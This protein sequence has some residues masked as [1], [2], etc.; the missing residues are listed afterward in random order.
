MFLIALQTSIPSVKTRKT[1]PGCVRS[2]T[3][4]P[5]DGMGDMT[6][7]RYLS[8]IC[9]QIRKNVARPWYVLKKSK[10][11]YIEK[12]IIVAIN[13]NLLKLP[14]VKRKMDEKNE[15]LLDNPEEE[16]PAEYDVANWKQFLPPLVP[17]KIKNLVN[18]SSE[19][20]KSL[21]S[22]LKSGVKSQEEQILVVHSKII[23]FS[24]AIQERIEEIVK[25]KDLILSKLKKGFGANQDDDKGFGVYTTKRD[26]LRGLEDKL[27]N[28]M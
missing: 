17:F 26:E 6:S 13:E 18:I 16:I 10:E 2:F 15:Y 7:V 22:H 19:F 11:D 27:R 9:Y 25:K 8:C 4:F 14:D 12:K 3:G 23:M 28:K 24:L 1:F 20:K 5:F 21:L